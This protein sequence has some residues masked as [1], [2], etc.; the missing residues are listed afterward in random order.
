[1]A[2][3]IKRATSRRQ[4][5]AWSGHG[6]QKPKSHCGP[7]DKKPTIVN[8]E[9]FRQARSERLNNFAKL[10]NMGEGF[11][12]KDDSLPKRVLTEPIKSRCI[13]R[14]FDFAGSSG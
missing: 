4:E 10:F 13:E 3:I 11:A 14:M 9:A 12:R 2:S 5:G 8:P 1:M 6:L 7:G